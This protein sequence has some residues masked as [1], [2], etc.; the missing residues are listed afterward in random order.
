MLLGVLFLL[1]GIIVAMSHLFFYTVG[2]KPVW[3]PQLLIAMALSGIAS[4]IVGIKVSRRG[5]T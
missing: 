3:I 2:W 1:P 4:I 5:Q